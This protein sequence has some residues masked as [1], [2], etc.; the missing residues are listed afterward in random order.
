MAN[1]AA[2]EIPSTGPSTRYAVHTAMLG[3]AL[4]L[5]DVNEKRK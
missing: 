2:L 5:R 3:E 4:F 1:R